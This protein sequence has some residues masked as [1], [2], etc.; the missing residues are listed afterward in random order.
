MKTQE[1]PRRCY[2]RLPSTGEPILILRGERGYWT[3]NL[4]LDPDAMNA[5]LG[6]TPAQR[7]AMLTGSMFGWDIP[8]AT[9][10]AN[11]DASD[12][13]WSVLDREAAQ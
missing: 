5:M 9:V 3:I 12:K 6:V 10:E 7:E 1:L 4:D 13:A 2:A 8:G 11:K